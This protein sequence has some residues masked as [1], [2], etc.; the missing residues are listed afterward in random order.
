ML[1]CVYFFLRLEKAVKKVLCSFHS[2]FHEIDREKLEV[3][4]KIV[5]LLQKQ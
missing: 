3:F 2:H 5:P 4:A 1:F